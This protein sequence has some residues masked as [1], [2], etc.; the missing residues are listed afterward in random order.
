MIPKIIHL[1]WFGG[2]MPSQLHKYINSWALHLWKD[3][4]RLMVW[5]DSNIGDYID[6]DNIRKSIENSVYNQ[7]SNYVRCNVLNEYGGFYMDT[8]VMM[9]GTFEKVLHLDSYF[10][11]ECCECPEK[12]PLV[13]LIDGHRIDTG[14]MGFSKGHPFLKAVIERWKALPY[15]LLT[16][17]HRNDHMLLGELMA[18]YINTESVPYRIVNSIKEAEDTE[19]ERLFPIFNYP[20]FDRCHMNNGKQDYGVCCHD[21]TTLWA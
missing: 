17:E 10:G 6:C 21:F 14:V 3:G 7:I 19:K 4:Y 2:E 16:R 15:S 20:N 1:C 12:R 11:L 9:H 13:R 5:N 18:T 8:D